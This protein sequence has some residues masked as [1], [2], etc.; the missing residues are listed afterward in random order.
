MHPERVSERARKENSMASAVRTR[1]HDEIRSW[2]E[3]RGGIPTLVKGTEGLLRIDFVKGA[4]SGGREASLEEIS[5][6]RWFDLFDDNDLSFLCS[7]EPDSKFFKLITRQP[8]D[9]DDHLEDEAD[10]NER[11]GGTS[12]RHAES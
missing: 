7:P 2:V 10:T 1:D 8:E 3:E 4:K 12:G 11:A 9:L 6:E 5:W